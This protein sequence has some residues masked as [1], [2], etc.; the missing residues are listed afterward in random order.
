M[1]SGAVHDLLVSSTPL[2][3]LVLSYDYGNKSLDVVDHGLE[4]V[5]S[6]L[7]GHKTLRVLSLFW[8]DVYNLKAVCFSDLLRNNRSIEVLDIIC[9]SLQGVATMLEPLVGA[10]A[11]QVLRELTVYGTE[12]INSLPKLK[13]DEGYANVANLLPQLTHLNKLHF[14]GDFTVPGHPQLAAELMGAFDQNLSLTSVQMRFLSDDQQRVI[15]YYAK[16]N[17]YRP[18]LAAASKAKMLLVDF[19]DLQA[20]HDDLTAISLMVETLVRRDDWFATT[21]S[22]SNTPLMLPSSKKRRRSNSS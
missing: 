16:R 1:C 20:N 2:E 22:F 17:E 11:N 15:Q 14:E 7:A 5:L 8:N 10:D 13:D 18:L 6:V 4:T 21:P 12:D 9:T 19:P 3:E